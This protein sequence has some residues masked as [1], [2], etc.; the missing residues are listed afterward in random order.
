M[1]EGTRLKRSFPLIIALVALTLVVPL[2]MAQSVYVQPMYQV[3]WSSSTIVVSVPANP[4]WALDSFQQAIQDWNQA[5]TWFLASY[6]PTHQNAKYTLQLA[7]AGQTPQVTVYYVSN[8]G[9]QWEGQ[10]SHFGTTVAIVL[11]LYPT[12]DIHDVT[13]LAEHELGHVLGLGDN[14]V[15]ADLM[16]SG[17][18]NLPHVGPYPSTLD[19]YAAYVQ[20]VSGDGYGNGNSV[21]LPLQ[22]PYLIW[23]P[24]VTQ[25][26]QTFTTTT[27][28][29]P[30]TSATHTTPSY[31]SSSQPF[32]LPVVP[33]LMVEIVA[34]A[35]II[36]LI[37]GAFLIYG[38]KHP[39]NGAYEYNQRLRN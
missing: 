25:V 10:T 37:I 28:S 30:Y 15:K 23:H 18:N 21:S 29:Q 38:K 19:L 1:N 5:Q 11:S 31:S 13:E 32:S 14:C 12:G 39:K 36:G 33:F 26:S 17:C 34:V 24:T 35:V 4:S 7:E 3:N 27:A 6:E 16:S 20:A 8:T 2:V 22:I 9:Q